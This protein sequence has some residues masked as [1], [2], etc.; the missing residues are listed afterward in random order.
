MEKIHIHMKDNLPLID[1]IL[2]PISYTSWLLGA[3]VAHPR[4]YSKIVTIIVHII[5][6]VLCIIGIILEIKFVMYDMDI[7]RSIYSFLICSC[8]MINYGST[9]YRIYQ[10]IR[11]YDKWSEL[12]DKIK[13]FDQKIR[14][15]ILIN[16]KPVK[17][18][19]V[20][21][22]LV[23]F[24]CCPLCII[25]N[26]LYYY[27]T[28][29]NPINGIDKI[30]YYYMLAQSL[31]NG[32]VFDIVVYVLYYR[33]QAIN[34]LIGQL[35]ELS[36]AFK[37]RRI[38]KMHNGVCDLVIMVND[39]Y[40][41]NLLICSVNCFTMV[42][43]Q[44]A[45]IYLVVTKIITP[46]LMYYVELITSLILYTMQFGLMC[47]NCTLVRREF[48]KTGIIMYDIVLNFKH[49]NLELKERRSQSNPEMRLSVEGPNSWQNSVWNSSHYLNN[50]AAKNLQHHAENLSKN[51]NCERIRN[52]MN[53]FLNQLQHSRVVFTA[54]DFFE[55][56]N[57][58]FSGFIG[59]IIVY[60]TIC[61]QFFLDMKASENINK[62]LQHV[63]QEI[64]RV[65]TDV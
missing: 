42:L 62:I 13:K 2:R 17:I 15:E 58:L 52:E 64:Q 4:K 35:N 28:Y 23:T 48:H 16:D 43:S 47:W 19:E 7:F 21:A 27:F 50:I 36:D 41:F 5:Y 37:I 44:L 18:A 11:Q 6:L 63:L 57:A 1:H 46:S 31:I 3:G 8:F 34:E 29:S 55:I 53:D 24:T 10:V 39:I 56:N 65:V 12:M 30:F 20:L 38:R 25:V 61:T 9:Y 26:I 14:K 49:T 40:G 60:L 32:F 51:L 33:L 54:Y 45:I 22:I 59:V